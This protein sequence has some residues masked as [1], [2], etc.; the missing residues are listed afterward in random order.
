ML[1]SIRLRFRSIRS[2]RA[3]AGS[4]SRNTGNCAAVWTRLTMI[5]LGARSVMIQPLAVFWIQV[6]REFTI[7]AT[8]SQQNAR[9][10]SG[11]QAELVVGSSS[12]SVACSSE[13][14]AGSSSPSGACPSR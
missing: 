12:P 2:A 13:L 6:P 7:L 1:V 8:H 9:L 11:A 3:P 14:V 5:G 4:A 10:A